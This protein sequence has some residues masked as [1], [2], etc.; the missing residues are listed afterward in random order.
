[1]QSHLCPDLRSQHLVW[2]R[3]TAR[4][5]VSLSSVFPRR[6][7]LSLRGYGI[8]PVGPAHPGN[9]AGERALHMELTPPS[10]LPA[11]PLA[12][13][14]LRHLL[15]LL[16]S[17]SF[18]QNIRHGYL[19]EKEAGGGQREKKEREGGIKGR[20]EGGLFR[21]AGREFTICFLCFLPGHCIK[22]AQ[23]QPKATS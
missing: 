4:L 2:H 3:G 22:G 6:A 19:I 18:P 13:L 12:P 7:L 11:A 14:S 23:G 5:P 16:F 1:M 17:F 10:T 9:R 20:R 21:R 15:L 8:L